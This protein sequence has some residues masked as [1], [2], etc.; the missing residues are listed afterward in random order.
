MR[1]HTVD[2]AVVQHNNLIGLPD[3]RRTLGYQED[4]SLFFMLQQSLPKLRVRSE[5][6]SRLL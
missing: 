1:A 6:Q 3:G 5:I 2:T 4:R